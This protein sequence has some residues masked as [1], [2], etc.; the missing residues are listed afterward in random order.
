MILKGCEDSAMSSSLSFAVAGDL[1]PESSGI[2]MPPSSSTSSF[3]AAQRAL[4]SHSP[5]F[6]YSQTVFVKTSQVENC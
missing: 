6:R 3:T 4:L 2:M 1:S 5:C